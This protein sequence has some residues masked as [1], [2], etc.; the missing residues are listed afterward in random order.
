MFA[1]FGVNMEPR[2]VSKFSLSKSI[3]QQTT[4]DDYDDQL[5]SLE[6]LRSKHILTWIHMNAQKPKMARKRIVGSSRKP[7]TPACLGYKW[8]SSVQCS[9]ECRRWW[10]PSEPKHAG[11]V[12]SFPNLPKSSHIFPYLSM[13]HDGYRWDAMVYRWHKLCILRCFEAPF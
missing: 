8:S 11:V 12:T 1:I 2:A 6:N 7:A 4:N 5:E 13:D 3:K 9:L 10:I